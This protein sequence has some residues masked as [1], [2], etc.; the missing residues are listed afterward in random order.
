MV[1][2]FKTYEAGASL[3]WDGIRRCGLVCCC[4]LFLFLLLFLGVYFCQKWLSFLLLSSHIG[5][6]INEMADCWQVCS[7]FASCQ[8]WHTQY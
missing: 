4:F 7:G 8:G 1:S 2:A 5:I 6:R 3:E